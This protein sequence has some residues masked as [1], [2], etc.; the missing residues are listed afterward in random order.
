MQLSI[1]K[2]FNPFTE[3]DYSYSK[4]PIPCKKK[5][6]PHTGKTTR[7]TT[8]LCICSERVCKNWKPKRNSSSK[9]YA[10][11]RRHENEHKLEY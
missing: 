4:R 3:H 6:D 11:N 10:S 8:R 5:Y 2:K 1:S 7:N 9:H